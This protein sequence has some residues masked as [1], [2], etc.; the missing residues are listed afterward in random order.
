MSTRFFSSLA[1]IALSALSARASALEFGIGAGSSV[2]SSADYWTPT[3]YL[4]IAGKRRSLGPFRWQPLASLAW[5]DGRGDLNDRPDL[6]LQEDVV[7]A[8]VGVRLVE[9]WRNAYF[10]FQAGY[11]NRTTSALSS[12]EQF[13]SAIGWQ[14]R[15]LDVSVRHVSNGSIFGGRNLGETTLL[16]GAHF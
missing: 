9:W 5:F 1:L 14:G 13:I 3:V 7:V 15:Y 6:Q 16:V 11:A 4:D 10:S 2:T 12:H 8:G